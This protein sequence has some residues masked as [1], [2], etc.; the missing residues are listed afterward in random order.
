MEDLF[1]K[2]CP[3]C[4][5]TFSVTYPSL[6]TYKIGTTYYCRYNCWRVPQKKGESMKRSTITLEQKKK[7]V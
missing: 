5:K 7:A 1:A 6:W 2:V 3:V 4:K